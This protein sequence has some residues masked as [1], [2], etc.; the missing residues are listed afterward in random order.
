M[1]INS[2]LALKSAI[3]PANRAGSSAASVSRRLV[4]TQRIG[5]RI[6]QFCWAAQ[7]AQ[8]KKAANT[9]RGFRE[10]SSF[11]MARLSQSAHHGSGSRG[12]AGA[13]RDGGSARRGG[14]AGGAAE[15][16]G[17]GGNARARGGGRGGSARRRRERASARRGS[18]RERPAEAGTNQPAPVSISRGRSAR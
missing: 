12:A 17:G 10:A 18:R 8:E 5:S 13:A 14:A 2:T 3:C 15:V 9:E 1:A 7:T 4:C 6:H 11:T 16:P